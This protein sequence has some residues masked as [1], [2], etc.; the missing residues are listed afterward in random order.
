MEKND[1][2]PQRVKNRLRGYDYNLMANYFI[3]I[4]TNQRKFL[5]GEVVGEEMVLND[6]GAMVDRCIQMIPHQYENAIVIRHVVMPNH[7]HLLLHLPEGLC[8]YDVIRNFKSFTTYEYID[9]VKKY[10]WI[11]FHKHLWQRSYYDHIIRDQRDYD[12]IENYIIDN[13]QRWAHDRFVG[14]DE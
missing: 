14:S 3:T 2:F 8:L 7:I 9:G 13:P 11:P 6:A 12:Q 5:F 4:V 1:I 10:G